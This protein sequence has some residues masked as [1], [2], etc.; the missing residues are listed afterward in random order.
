[1]QASVNRM[2]ALK[3]T[4]QQMQHAARETK[5]MRD[6]TKTMGRRTMQP[7]AMATT[8]AEFA[9]AKDEHDMVAEV[10]QD[11]LDA[12]GEYG[13][14]G[15]TTEEELALM[16]QRLSE[17]VGLERANELLSP[18]TKEPV[19]DVRLPEVPRGTPFMSS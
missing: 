17:Q 7:E 2:L 4:A 3:S 18:P 11:S 1:M 6:L 13:E 9:R 5:L 8:A 12:A 10:V 15:R 19:V 14:D 16:R